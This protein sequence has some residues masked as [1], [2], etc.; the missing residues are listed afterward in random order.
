MTV[1][2]PVNDAKASDS[3]SAD[4]E[5]TGYTWGTLQSR[6]RTSV[7]SICIS[8]SLPFDTETN[9]SSYAT[10]FV[11]D[12]EQGIILSNRHVMGSGPT[13]HKATFFD[14][15]EVY[16]QP[17]YYDPEHDF[18]FFRYIP[19]ELKNISPKAIRLAPHKAR[20]GLEIRVIGNDSNEKMSVHQGEL[21]QLDRNV[22]EYGSN[23]YESYNDLNTFY[24]QASTSSKG[25][26][27]GS[28][29][30]D[31]EGDAVAIN[32]GGNFQSSSNFFLPLERVLYAFD[33][34]LRKEIP[35]RGTLQ[36]VFKH[37][38]HVQ[39]ERLGLSEEVA[40][41]EGVATK[42]T[43]GVLT[44]NKVLVDGPADG[45]LLV[46][47]IVV[48]AN[49]TLVPGF[50]DLFKIIDAS[51]GDK[52]DL[53]VFSKG[54]FKTVSVAVQDL[55]SITPSAMLQIGNTYLHNL[56][57]QQA[58]R[59]SAPVYG[60]KIC[61]SLG[62]FFPSHELRGRYVIHAIN[63]T[64]TPNL[65]ALMDV[66]RDVRRGEPIVVLVKDHED[67]RDEAVF[68]TH[69]PP[70]GPSNV[71]YTRSI[72]TG[73]WSTKPYDG[74]AASV[75]PLISAVQASLPSKAEIEADSAKSA[76]NGIA[77]KD[78]VGDIQESTV[79]IE[80]NPICP[81]DGQYY[82]VQRGSG[83]VV[84]KRRGLILCSARLVGNPT[85]NISVT[86]AGMVRV[87]AT[88]AYI[89]PL[90][91]VAFVK[92]DPALIVN[93]AAGNNIPDLD[94]H[95]ARDVDGTGR[96]A[97]G[98][99]VTV[100]TG[101]VSGGLEIN[102]AAVSGRKLLSTSPCTAC[103]NQRFFN[104]EVFMLSPALTEI[105]NEI[106]IVCNADGRICG[107][108]LRLLHC[109]HSSNN[110]KHVGLDISLV[111]PT[112]EQLQTNDIVPD[113][114]R[115]LD[116]EFS[117]QSL[118]TAKAL[119]VSESHVQSIIQSAPT[120]RNVLKV[121]KILRIRPADTVSLE[122]GDVVLSVNGH[123][124][125]HIDNL[126]CFYNC[127][128]VELT[129]IRRREVLTLTVPTLPIRSFN[130]RRIIHWAGMFLQE[131]YQTVLQQAMR[132]ASQVYNFMF[133]SGGP[134]VVESYNSNM[135][136]CE[137]G[138]HS[139]QTLDDVAEA[140]RNLKSK[141]LAEFNKQVANGLPLH[142]G[143]MPGCDVRIHVVLLNGEDVVRSI[144]TNDQ[145]FPAWQLSRG[146]RI[147]DNWVWEEL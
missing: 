82:P 86:F 133:I 108:W 83:L 90:Y 121:C 65:E 34:I 70:V 31:I 97:T 12:T 6:L 11:V 119:G 52:V 136:I 143:E 75:N 10:G 14:N 129:I 58:A 24:Y 32:C 57:F 17:L 66:L 48:R 53:R 117:H 95:L 127:D 141:K 33:Y 71:L 84:D 81:A 78:I 67:P 28:P 125:N 142:S 8:F 56:S 114:V 39:A 40:A 80:A 124:V 36:V 94:L 130:T 98:N 29:V 72:H 88:L 112:L 7:V 38:T 16:L 101:T 69:C 4:N 144:R 41:E 102:T 87:R 46:G 51:V 106:G 21:S 147:D 120:V 63:N 137:I 5:E 73:F 59:W 55:Y 18:S 131:P 43:T 60:V 1:A 110:K 49:G 116:V 68:V 138:E 13:Y 109:S 85:C 105:E 132:P 79:F 139:I 15:Q 140:A 23:N 115:V 77:T 42:D 134:I 111:L 64:P 74:L 37:V 47:D 54:A 44:V 118:A 128:S 45:L 107:L 113:F 126:A 9:Y 92:Y 2:A 19:S 26:S 35:S 3:T 20:S 93:S 62:G 122:V 146:P 104:T 61:K 123:T 91:P 96:L 27:S 22:P 76:V 145:Y 103:Y 100:V 50:A 135:F 89:H 25:G 99:L 30:V